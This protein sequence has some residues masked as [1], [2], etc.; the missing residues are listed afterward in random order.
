MREADSDRRRGLA[1]ILALLS[2]LLDASSPPLSSTLLSAE[3]AKAQRREMA[4]PLS[5]YPAA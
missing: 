3:E 5:G 4:E 2:A 1:G